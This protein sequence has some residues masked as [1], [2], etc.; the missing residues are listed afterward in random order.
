MFVFIGAVMALVQGEL[1]EFQYQTYMNI[2]N[3]VKSVLFN[4]VTNGPL[5]K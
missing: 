2:N 3:E 5:R 4:A 1:L